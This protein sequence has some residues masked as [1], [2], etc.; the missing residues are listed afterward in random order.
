M[1]E[2]IESTAELVPLGTGVS[3]LTA[4]QLQAALALA[5][6]A[7]REQTAKMVGV[8]PS[9]IRNWKNDEEFQL[10][11]QRLQGMSIDVLMEPITKM[12]EELTEGVRAA[13]K[14]LIHIAQNAESKDGKPAYGVRTEAAKVLMQYGI[15]LYQE[16]ARFSRTTEASKAPTQAV[17]VVINP[18]SGPPG[19]VE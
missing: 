11:V 19:V 8:S 18:G 15:S 7:N 6:G 1:T 9:T 3:S 16:E 5:G 10:E 4:Q 12:K 13:I 14:E 2:E 17:Q